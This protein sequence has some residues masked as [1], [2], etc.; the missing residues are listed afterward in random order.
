MS[1][2]QRLCLMISVL[3][4]NDML[5][6]DFD[7]YPFLASVSDPS[8][9]K[10][11][12]DSETEALAAEI[13]SFL[14]DH[15]LETGGH[16]AS[17]LGV[18]E[19]TLALH[20]VFD[21]PRD[22]IV[23]DVGHQSYV[24]KIITGRKERFD[25][26]RQPGGLS[27]F[28][29]R[30]ESEYDPFGAG[31]SST[32]IS[33]ALGMA[34][35]ER[36]RGSDAYTIA[37]VGDG[38]FT[39]GMIHEALN[40]CEDTQGLR[41]I[42]IINENEMSIS[43]NIGRFA[44]SISKIRTRPSYF[45]T[46][47]ATR[48][49]LTH[50]PLIGNP[51]LSLL[52]K[53]KKRLKNALYESNYFENLGLYYIGPIDG[54]DL[55]SVE[56][57]LREAKRYNGN[58]VLH[59]KT[60]KGK[61]YAPAERTPEKYHAVPPAGSAPSGGF[62][63]E[64]GSVLCGLAR[65]DPRVCAITAA[66]SMGTGL[67]EFE[68]Q[69]PERFFDVGIAEEHAITFASGLSAGGMRPFCAV[70]STFLQRAYDNIIHDAALQRLPVVFAVDRAGLNSGDG[71]T[72]HGIFDVSFLSSVPGMTIYTPATYDALRAAMEQAAASALP[73]AIR[74]PN[75][76]ESEQVMK[77]FYPEGPSDRIGIRPYG[78]SANTRVLLLVHGRMAQTALD[79]LAL[80]A[81][82]KPQVGIILCEF[83][84]PYR[85][86]AGEIAAILPDS[87][88]LIVTMEEEIRSGGFGMNLT[89][90]LRRAGYGEEKGIRLEIIAADDDFV[91]PSEGQTVF[92]AAGVDA[93]SSAEKIKTWL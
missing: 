58:V 25:T 12:S 92:E 64:F 63:R 87:V 85:K 40:N 6:N 20:R 22:N 54:N 49:F 77:T 89:D 23:F 11:L 79:T 10:K 82:D 29:R 90:A 17:N 26:L 70:Y 59:L 93:A 88:R 48:G 8:D 28:T 4:P 47:A 3:P 65:H 19:L 78:L 7:K 32:S 1:R 68:Q 9:L 31:H 61:G 14:V 60:Q 36:L 18:V 53:I 43:K 81:A 16:L 30:S 55:V 21:A 80:L 91:I 73:A 44:T 38:A 52:T 5:K 42:I 2:R 51:L 72:H 15:V 56:N 66:M 83:I 84:K 67:S 69:Y 27:G 24:H 39:G 41:L 62:S 57:M 35:A 74:Y 45:R 13:R 76:T 34:Q 50:I 37:V 75:G 33:A 86:L 71:A 46:K